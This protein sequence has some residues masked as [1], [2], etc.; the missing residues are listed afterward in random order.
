MLEVAPFTAWVR[1]IGLLD[2]DLFGLLRLAREPPGWAWLAVVAGAVVTGA[3]VAVLY[4]AGEAVARAA[5]AVVAALVL[6]AGVAGVAHLVRVVTA[7]RGLVSV[8]PG[9]YLVGM[10]EIALLV[11]VALP[12]RTRRSGGAR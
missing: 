12:R 10:S 7:S 11:A 8:G 4:E 1:L 5:S 9:L 2:A 6:A 3:G